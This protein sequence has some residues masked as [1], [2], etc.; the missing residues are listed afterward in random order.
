MSKYNTG[1]HNVGS[2]LVSGRPHIEQV[3][4]TTNTNQSHRVQFAS[5]TKKIIVRTTSSHAVRIHFAPFTAS[6]NFD[7]GATTNNN[8]I[9]L[10]GSGQIELDVKCEEIF[11]SAPAGA[12]SSDVVEIYGE[13]TNIPAGRMF[14]LN[15]LVG[16]NG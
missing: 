15:G 6:L 10:S 13:L 7:P 4:L 5:V 8:F 9:T 12:Y 16:V 2:Y 1:L 14:N 3:S 11:I